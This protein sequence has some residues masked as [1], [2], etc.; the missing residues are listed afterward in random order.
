MLPDADGT[1]YDKYG[2]FLYPAIPGIFFILVFINNFN[3]LSLDKAIPGSDSAM[4]LQIGTRYYH[5]L[6]NGDLKTFFIYPNEHYPNLTYQLTAIFQR[7]FGFNDDMA[8]LS[9]F[10]FWL[11]LICSTYFISLK[12]FGEKAGALAAV[13]SLSSAFIVL[14]SQSYLLDIPSAAMTAFSLVCLFYCESFRKSGWTLAFF[15]CFAIAMLIKWSSAFFIVI[16]F[17][18]CF[19]SFLKR[20]LGE[21]SLSPYFIAFSAIS[22]ATAV[23]C[24]VWNYYHLRRILLAGGNPLSVYLEEIAIFIVLLAIISSINF[25]DISQKRF[26][27]GI[28]LF[29]ILIWHFY[30]FNIN[31]LVDFIKIQSDTA[32]NRGDAS[33]P[34]SL[35]VVN[36]LTVIS[37]PGI[38]LILTGII[39]FLAEKEDSFD[40]RLFLWA[41]VGSLFI[42]F[43]VPIKDAR[44]F[45]PLIPFTA[46]LQTFWIFRIRQRHLRIFVLSLFLILSFTGIMGWRLP[47][48]G[49]LPESPLLFN[50]TEG[51]FALPPDEKDWK[52][53]SIEESICRYS[54]G[55]NTIILALFEFEGNIRCSPR[56]IIS[57]Y[58]RLQ[59]GE[60][61]WP[62]TMGGMPGSTFRKQKGEGG[63]SYQFAL[64]PLKS[65]QHS[66]QYDNLLILYLR[67]NCDKLDK[68]TYLDYFLL[69]RNFTGRLIL[70][71]RMELPENI[72][73]FVMEM[74]VEPPL[75]N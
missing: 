23:C 42:L 54:S 38:L 2:K 35:F 3:W 50:I 19:A 4:H 72:T 1:F 12:L 33:T 47:F 65:E 11:I 75:D 21:K 66:T 27:Q 64:A 34:L 29:F 20:L 44:Y 36:F 30:G 55:R 71:E 7:F 32:I 53:R 73:L 31:S 45:A 22:T 62:E 67:K 6:I 10:P 9:Q 74:K 57:R 61:I 48:Y 46:I 5:A 51:I 68:N 69:D 39:W 13:A 43:L 40:R 58:S 60:L 17:I 24:P 49:K 63:C 52:I 18:I 14:L 56:D 41:F 28:I 25:K 37:I 15:A 16:P 59:A 70:R 8:V 26:L